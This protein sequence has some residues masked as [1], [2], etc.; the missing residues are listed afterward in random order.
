MP[1]DY[2][3][4][5]LFHPL[6]RELMQRIDFHHGGP[7]YDAK[8]PDGIPT[9]VEIEHRTLGALASGLVMYPEGHARNQSGNLNGLLQEKFLRLAGLGVRDVHA[10]YARMTSLSTKMPA[11]IRE[12]YSFDIEH[13]RPA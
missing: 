2:N 1:D 8:Y 12:L 11:E 3:D 9:S 5:A 10:L 4:T 13:V 6:T 7:Q